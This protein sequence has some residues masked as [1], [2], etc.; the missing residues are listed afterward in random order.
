LY[1]FDSI[2]IFYV[3]P[4]GIVNLLIWGVIG[5]CWWKFIGLY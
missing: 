4:S 3:G 5:G 1:L 2:E